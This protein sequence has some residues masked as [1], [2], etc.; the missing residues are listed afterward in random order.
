MVKVCKHNG[1]FSQLSLYL[2]SARIPPKYAD[3]ILER[4]L[5]K[6]KTCCMIVAIVLIPLF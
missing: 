1:I 2:A 3:Y 4:V 6:L 5:W